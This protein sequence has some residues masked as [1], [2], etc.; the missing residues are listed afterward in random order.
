MTDKSHI[1][2]IKFQYTRRIVRIRVSKWFWHWRVLGVMSGSLFMDMGSR[3]FRVCRNGGKRSDLFFFIYQLEFFF[4]NHLGRMKSPG[5]IIFYNI[6]KAIDVHI[7]Y[8]PANGGRM[9]LFLWIIL[10]AQ[11]T[12]FARAKSTTQRQMIQLSLPFFKVQEAY[13]S[14]TFCA[15]QSFLCVAIPTLVVFATRLLRPRHHSEITAVQPISFMFSHL[16]FSFVILI[17]PLT[18]EGVFFPGRTELPCTPSFRDPRKFIIARANVLNSSASSYF[19]FYFL[20]SRYFY[21]F[22]TNPELLSRWLPKTGSVLII[23][24]WS[25]L[26]WLFCLFFLQSE[27]MQYWIQSVTAICVNFPRIRTKRVFLTQKSHDSIMKSFYS[28][29]LLIS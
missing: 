2:T 29:S 1:C 15:V 3:E 20:I 23:S 24:C 19:L 6:A 10:F 5:V 4:V 14:F 18:M 26:P 7:L 25:G 9:P 27:R 8:H 11:I 12:K 13:I 21:L 17:N 22:I 28:S 16:S